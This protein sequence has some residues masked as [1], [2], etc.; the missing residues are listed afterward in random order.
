MGT[1]YIFHRVSWFLFLVS[2]SAP[3]HF[4]CFQYACTQTLSVLRNVQVC[5]AMSW[6]FCAMSQIL[7]F[8]LGQCKWFNVH[9]CLFTFIVYFNY[10]I[11]QYPSFYRWAGEVIV[12]IQ[13]SDMSSV[14]QHSGS[15][16]GWLRL[17]FP[18]QNSPSPPLSEYDVNFI[19]K[20][21]HFIH[22]IHNV[23]WDSF[24]FLIGVDSLKSVHFL[25]TIRLW[26][27]C[28]DLTAANGSDPGVLR[29]VGIY[30]WC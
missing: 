13:P 29:H 17:V 3:T 11:V 6:V 22:D 27:S 30:T 12:Y 4:T 14:P 1:S 10:A 20:E 24:H 2:F 26:Q 23:Q 7:D 5:Y 19:V 9:L 28:K 25:L 8:R 16:H 15:Y 18:L 21:L